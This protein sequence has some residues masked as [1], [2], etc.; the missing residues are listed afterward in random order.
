L[1]VENGFYSSICIFRS[2]NR[3]YKDAYP[4]QSTQYRITAEGT[5]QCPSGITNIITI[6]V[7]DSVKFE[8]TL[9]KDTICLG[10]EMTISVSNY[11][12]DADLLKWES[13]KQATAISLK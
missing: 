7:E 13:K 8:A 4:T 3:Y 9:D 10:S 2:I 6:F 11:N 5:G 12:F 1:D